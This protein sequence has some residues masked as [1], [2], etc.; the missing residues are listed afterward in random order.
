MASTNIGVI[1]AV[2][3]GGGFYVALLRSARISRSHAAQAGHH[4]ASRRGE[5]AAGPAMSLS[6]W[7]QQALNSIKNELAGSDPE[8]AA[9]I[10]AF[11]G[12]ASDVEMPDREKI[13]AGSRRALR[14]LNRARW[15]AR[16][17]R[18]GQRLGFRRPALLL[19]L[20]TTAV[21]VA[22]AVVTVSVGGGHSTCPETAL[23]ICT[24]PAPRHSPGSPSPDTTTSQMPSQRAVGIPAPIQTAPSR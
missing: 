12:L 19:W 8:L 9:L 21:L 18:V 14:R 24:S 16:F 2:H 10:S 3:S 15:R 6:A 7:E 13:G 4:A 5:A 20:L 22:A 11:N 1:N 23:M 17:R